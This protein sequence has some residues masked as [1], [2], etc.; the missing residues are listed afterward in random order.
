MTNM[1]EAK[2]AREAEIR[3]VSVAMVT[4][5][6]CWRENEENV[7]VSNIIET[8][9]QNAKKAQILIK[10]FIS[11][12]KLKRSESIIDGVDNVLDKAI[13]TNN[14][15]KEDLIKAGLDAVAGRIINVS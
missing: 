5:Y 8:M 3:Y 2:L 12:L 6:D 9:N 1:P 11:N 10:S 7:D 15:N 4:D 14:Y 13:I